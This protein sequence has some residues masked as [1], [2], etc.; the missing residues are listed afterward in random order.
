MRYARCPADICQNN[1][2]CVESYFGGFYCDCPVRYEGQGAFCEG[3]T[4]T[5][6]SEGAFMAFEELGWHSQL[7]IKLR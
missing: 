4:R 2:T 7:N 1:G 3:T 6:P 5:F